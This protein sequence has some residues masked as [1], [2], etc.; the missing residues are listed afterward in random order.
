[1][2]TFIR[3]S[4]GELEVPLILIE[5]QDL[6]SQV[7]KA[8]WEYLD[9]FSEKCAERMPQRHWWDHKIDLTPDFIPKKAKEI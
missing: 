2:N 3:W 5:E 8:F 9:M 7:P 1:M 4:K 6:C